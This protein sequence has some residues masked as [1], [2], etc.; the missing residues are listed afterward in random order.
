M[1]TQYTVIMKV[2]LETP[3]LVGWISCDY[4]T[5][6]LGSIG[7][8]ANSTRKATQVAKNMSLFVLVFIIQWW[9]IAVYGAWQLVVES[10]PLAMLVFLTTFSNI[11]GVLNGIVFLIM[12]RNKNRQLAPETTV[13]STSQAHRAKNPPQPWWTL[14][15]MKTISIMSI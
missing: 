15:K 2:I 6:F 12:R 11:G 7:E 5:F 9:A 8:K 14:C 10:V 3:I 13:V 4:F 1:E